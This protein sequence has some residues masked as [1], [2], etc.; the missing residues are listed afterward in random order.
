MKRALALVL[1]FLA[2]ACVTG[3]GTLLA[4]P[5]L[6]PQS[7]HIP[8]IAV[9]PN[10]LPAVMPDAERWR[11]FCWRT[12]ADE[13]R[14]RGYEVAGYEVSTGAFDRAGLDFDDTHSSRD[15]W[16]DLASSL[17]VDAI[18]VPSYAVFGHAGGV[19]FITRYTYEAVVNYQLYLAERNEFVARVEAYGE[20]G[21]LTG[22]LTAGGVGVG[23]GGP[24]IGVDSGTAVI[25][26]ALMVGADV[27]ISLILAG[28]GSEGYWED[29]LGRAIHDGLQPL[30]AAFPER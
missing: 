8:R 3:R 26:A 24:A 29:A 5:S 9:V 6:R 2:E 18:L 1:L 23:L 7:V 14:K 12:A 30:M 28:R 11:S 27:V 10:R 17:Q 16:A 4:D 21:Y 25:P 15:K 22:L 19:V 20:A 13:L